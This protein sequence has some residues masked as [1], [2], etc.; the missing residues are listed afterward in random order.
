MRE[1]MAKRPID[2]TTLTFVGPDDKVREAKKAM[3][4]LGFRATNARRAPEKS[5]PWRESR[6]YSGSEQLPGVF[7]VGARY[8]EGLT[9]LELSQRTGIQRRH[10][11]EMECGKRPIGKANA[12]KLADVLNIDPRRLLT[13]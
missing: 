12:R 4:I 3:R 1:L 8:R 2:A 10:I 6:H 5:I 7:L 11:S 13:V 9:Q